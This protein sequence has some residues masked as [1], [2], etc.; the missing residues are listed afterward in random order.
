VPKN[1]EL[2]SGALA[3]ECNTADRGRGV[4]N[5]KRGGGVKT[6]T[7]GTERGYRRYT[8]P[9]PMTRRGAHENIMARYCI[10]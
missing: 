10:I 2:H 4:Y 7:R 5:P 8:V 1:R 6:L 3:V 9:G